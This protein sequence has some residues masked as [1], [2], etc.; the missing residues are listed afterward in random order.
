[1]DDGDTSCSCP[2]SVTDDVYQ[3]GQEPVAD[4]DVIGTGTGDAHSSPSP[5]IALSCRLGAQ[6][7]AL[8]CGSGPDRGRRGRRGRWGRCS[9]ALRRHGC[10]NADRLGGLDPEGDEDEGGDL[11]RAQSVGGYRESGYLGV[12]R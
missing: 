6:A 1:M 7:A 8:R 12:Q 5:A 9:I 4:K 2:R 3:V 10:Q 11:L